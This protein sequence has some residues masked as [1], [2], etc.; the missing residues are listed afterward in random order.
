MSKLI[1]LTGQR[2]GILTVLSKDEPYTKPSGQKATMWKCICDCGN[3]VSIRSEYLR[4]GSVTSCGCIEEQQK[5]II[6]QRFGRLVVVKEDVDKPKSVICKCDCGELTSVCRHNLLSGQTKSCGCLQKEARYAKVND[7]TG[8]KFGRLTVLKRVE[9]QGRAV[10]YL[11]RCECGNE[12]IFY[13]TNL[14][15]GLSIS[16]GCFRRDKLSQLYFEDLTG[17]TFGR[18]TIESLNSYDEKN[19]SYFWN[20]I[21]ECG[22]KT[23]VSSNHLKNGHTQ[24]CGCMISAGEEKI[25]K[26]LSDNHI[27][28]KKGLSH[29][30]VLP[31]GGSA[32]YDFSIFDED[33]KLQYLIEYD[34]WQHYIKSDSKWDNDGRFEIR[35]SSDKLKNEWCIDNNIFL[36]RI[37]YTHFNDICLNDLQLGTTQFLI[38]K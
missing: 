33:S 21:C 30:L 31:T 5:N 20:C 37:P 6:G 4:N 23:I 34:G 26:I 35:Q 25:A 32:K 10:R 29:G 11:C 9:N 17:Q 19:N 7:L 22:T 2:F 12:K 27:I 36:I 28:F 3:I 13:A 38:N 24:S 18:L 16:C 1:D 14:K 15:R 8:Q